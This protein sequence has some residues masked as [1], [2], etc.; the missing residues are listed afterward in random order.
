MFP[1]FSRSLVILLFRFAVPHSFLDS[2]PSVRFLSLL[3][4]CLFMNLFLFIGMVVYARNVAVSV[5][6]GVL[7]S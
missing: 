5:I 7:Q 4:S 3:L 1:L 2:W 6:P